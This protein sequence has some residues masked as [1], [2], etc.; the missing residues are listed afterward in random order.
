MAIK[1]GGVATLLKK[2]IKRHIIVG[3]VGHAYS[4]N[5]N[6]LSKSMVALNLFNS[7]SMS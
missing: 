5:L 4:G 7:A 2:R 6:M 1:T 3:I